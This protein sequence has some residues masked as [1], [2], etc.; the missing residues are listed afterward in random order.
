M[1]YKLNGV[2]N[3][4]IHFMKK[5]SKTHNLNVVT[6]KSEI[7]ELVMKDEAFYFK[8]DIFRNL[9][10]DSSVKVLNSQGTMMKESLEKKALETI[11]DNES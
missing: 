4:I 1:I 10:V 2:W 6:L 7:N 8:T 3:Q 11:A 5:D 9:K